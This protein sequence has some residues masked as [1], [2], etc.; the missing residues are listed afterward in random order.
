[1]KTA[2]IVRGHARTWNYIKEHNINFFNNAY[3]YPDWC[4]V[5]P[6]TGTVTRES[7][8]QDF[9]GSNLRSIQLVSD[10]HYPF[11]DFDPNDYANWGFR[12]L[13]YWRQA[14]LDYMGG[15]A[16][17][18]H[19]LQN[20]IRYTNIIGFRPDNWFTV[21]DGK[22]ENSIIKKELDPMA[23]SNINYSGDMSFNDWVTSDFIWRAGPAAADIYCMRFLDSY[24]AGSIPNQF[25]HFSEHV[26]P[27]Y[28]QARNFLDGRH[29][30]G[31]IMEQIV[32]PNAPLP[33][34]KDSYN[35]NF[36][37]VQWHELSIEERRQMCISLKIN[38]KDYQIDQP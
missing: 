30:V 24:L 19:E 22:F 33:W 14:W 27:A 10:S 12:T 7:L 26:L 28:Y 13:A 38:P 6:D 29:T 4:I 37:K 1:M 36:Y 32:T 18:K 35:N 15:L 11:K 9:R 16:K 20:N 3:D 21:G 8:I 5:F 34:T 31:H 25:I 23:I 17:R 2:I